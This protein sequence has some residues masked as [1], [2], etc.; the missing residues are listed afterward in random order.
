MKSPD[1]TVAAYLDSTPVLLKHQNFTE[2]VRAQS[3]EFLSSGAKCSVCISY[4]DSL[5]GQYNRWSKSKDDK[6]PPRTNPNSHANY[7]Y[8]SSQQKDKRLSK[9]KICLNA[10][11]TK[12][13]R[14]K[15]GQ[16][17]EVCGVSVD[18]LHGELVSI[19]VQKK[20]EMERTHKEGSFQWLF[21]EQQLSNAQPNHL[22]DFTVTQ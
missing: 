18:E 12:H 15:I 6:T 4:R 22:K 19:M 16:S 1:G 11:E 8:L 21:W 5:R 17:T 10:A 2:T 14:E 13:L 9:L 20:E 7:R 3:C